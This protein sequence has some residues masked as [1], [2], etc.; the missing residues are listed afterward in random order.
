MAFFL[1]TQKEVKE[2]QQA[3]AE[4][5]ANVKHDVDTLYQWINYL[6]A[7]NQQLLEQ[8]KAQK[9][10]IEQQHLVIHELKV[11]LAH[12]PKTVEEIKHIIDSHYNLEPIFT[13]LRHIEARIREL[14][15]KKKHYSPSKISY[16]LPPSSELPV[17][18]PSVSNLKE[19]IARRLVRNSKNYVKNLIF[20]L[21]H[22]YDKIS[23]LQL[24]DIVVDEQG[25]CSKSSFYRILE[26]MEKE[27]GLSTLG[28][29]KNKTYVG[30]IVKR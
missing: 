24:R 25:L 8:A 3:T 18:K 12:M 4:G 14:E 23:S 26:E 28:H 30:Q 10:L 19:K 17:E 9:D 1:A 11:N 2:I 20:G 21:V 27:G 29:G 5:F 7:Q 15:F 22:K 16:E 6:Y 13:Q